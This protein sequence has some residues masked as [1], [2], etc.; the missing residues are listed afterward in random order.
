LNSKESTRKTMISRALRNENSADPVAVV[1]DAYA[2]VEYAL[3][4]LSS[5]IVKERLDNASE[6]FTPASVIAELKESML[7]HKVRKRIIHQMISFVKG[8][9]SVVEIDSRIAELAGEVNFHR[10]KTVKDWGMLDSLVFSVSIMKKAR[11]LT[12]DPHFK[13]LSNVIYIGK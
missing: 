10:K 11:L 4:G 2:W 8:K 13:D 12:G 7:R 6:A 9:S 3:D 1:F 5:E